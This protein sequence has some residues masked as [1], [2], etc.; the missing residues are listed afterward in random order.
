VKH[1]FKLL[2]VFIVGV[3]LTVTTAEADFAALTQDA[4]VDGANSQVN[5][6]KGTKPVLW[7]ESVTPK[8]GLV[9][10]DLSALGGSVLSAVLTFNVSAVD[11]P[12]DVTVHV[13]NGPW[14]ETNV[15]FNSL[16]TAAPAA[17]TITVTAGDLGGTVSIDITEIAQAWVN[18][19][20]NNFGLTLLSSGAN[21]RFAS[22]E[23][24]LGAILDVITDGG[25]PPPP[26][27]E[28]GEKLSLSGVKV[29]LDNNLLLIQGSN[30]DNGNT[31]VVSLGDLGELLEISPYT[32]TMIQTNL[33]LGLPDGDYRLVVSTGPNEGQSIGYDL[34]IGAVG[35]QGEI[36]PQGIQGETGPAGPQGPIGLRGA[37]GP[38]GEQ[39]LPGADGAI[40]PIGPQGIQGVQGEI[41]PQG[42]QGETGPAGPAGSQGEQG[43]SGVISFGVKN[44]AGGEGALSSN[45]TGYYN[46]AIGD[47]ALS[48][49]TDG[50]FNTA[51]GAHALRYSTNT[52]N[53]AFGANSLPR[54]TSG[55]SNTGV[56]TNSLWVNT[57]GSSNTA[58]GVG[59]LQ[60]N[61]TG[62]NNI[63]IGQQAGLHLKTGVLN[64]MIDNPGVA[65]ESRTIRIGDLGHQRT[66]LAGII[67]NDLSASGVP[68]VIDANGQLGTSTISLACWDLNGDGVQDPSEDT[69][70]DTLFDALD[71]Q[72][73]EGPQGEAGATGPQ[74]PAGPQGAT[75]ATGPKGATGATGSQGPQGVEGP[76]GPQ[77]PEGPQGPAA[78]F[79]MVATVA[80]S[81][82]DYTSPLD[83]MANV[84]AGDFWC[85]IPSAANRCLVYIM[86]GV[87]DLAGNALQL[88]PFVDVKGSGQNVTT[89]TGYNLQIETADN[90]AVRD[91]TVE[92][93][94][95]GCIA[96][97]IF[98][99]DSVHLMDVT[100]VTG[101][102]GIHSQGSSSVTLSNINM[103]FVGGRDDAISPVIFN[104]TS[105]VIIENSRI[106]GTVS[107]A[108]GG[109]RVT[110]MSILGGSDVIAK[111]LSIEI[112]EGGSFFGLEGISNWGSSLILRD[113]DISLSGGRS[114]VGLLLG[115]GENPNFVMELTNTEIVANGSVGYFDAGIQF[116]TAFT[117]NVVRINRST[118]ESTSYAIASFGD[119]IFNID[120]SN[121][122]GDLT[123]GT[124]KIGASKLV[125]EVG[126]GIYKCVAS[127]NG[128]YDPLSADCL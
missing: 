27:P 79:A 75:G 24:G 11:V 120:A 44:T 2:S 52:G 5:K 123:E 94:G 92:C 72:G 70:G 64:I 122:V 78:A 87:Y 125:G 18:Y 43:P 96:I 111:G 105:N 98:D 88:S 61:T 12:G 4:Y 7:V 93:V 50:I 36:G 95:G 51:F 31:P 108:H 56:G 100:V 114:Q 45:T 29:D 84:N 67:G 99:D 83:A 57:T 16:P 22:L 35:P 63:A 23:S 116:S 48:Q 68:V 34:T 73:L 10:F 91:L 60:N 128:N 47:S 127:Y 115:N 82:G 62:S 59:A 77:G 33:P 42:I 118:I 53:S 8:H 32:P 19:P 15:T 101:Y 121:L 106:T 54:N 46:T 69:N 21:T 37:A 112:F 13:L 25:E 1:V 14:N 30:F 85:G 110:G 49:N 117:T 80:L 97:S 109:D 58:I 65:G 124:Y 6:N 76:V 26:P 103:T 28:P 126:V 71:C 66:F 74:G 86:P 41:G 81:G 89:L 113:V 40:G 55:H 119:A 9:Q 90:T 17:G 3:L 20:A 104:S 38:Q 39:G 102:Y 107:S